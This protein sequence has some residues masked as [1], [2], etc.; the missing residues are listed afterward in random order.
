[1]ALNIKNESTCEA[2]RK[3]AKVRGVGLT[4]AVDSA[5]RA[6]LAVESDS[7][8]DRLTH[9]LLAI[10]RTCARGLREPYKS[11]DHAELLYDERGF[12]K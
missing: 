2:I 6:S 7:A 5:V 1:M 8:R 4:E 12:P 11:M 10:G 3:L 9:D